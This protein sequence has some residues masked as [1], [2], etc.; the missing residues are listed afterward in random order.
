MPERHTQ[1]WLLLVDSYISNMYIYTCVH[2][3]IYLFIHLY[4]YLQLS[5]YVYRHENFVL[6]TVSMD[7]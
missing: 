1:S 2:M 5:I 6:I 4:I 7:S 3:D